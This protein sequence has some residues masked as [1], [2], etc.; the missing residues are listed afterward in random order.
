MDLEAALQDHTI[1]VNVIATI[2]LFLAVFGLRAAGIGFI[3]SQEFAS[4]EDRVRWHVRLRNL[5]LM[6]IIVFLIVIWAEELRTLALSAIAIA[7][8][9]VIAT[10]EMIL[11]ISGGIFR[12]ST[13]TY[14]VGD[15]IEVKGM[16]GDVQSYGL[17]ATKLLEIGPNSQKTGRAV[18]VPHSILLSEPVLNETI[19]ES[20]VLHTIRIPLTS[21]ENWKKAEEDLLA[22]AQEVTTPFIADARKRMAEASEKYGLMRWYPEPKTTLR[23]PE[24]GKIDVIVRLPTPINEKGITEQ[25]VIRRYL[26]KQAG[27]SADSKV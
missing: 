19:M 6:A 13:D 27:R 9:I 26:E 10:K 1:V 23:I 20:Y 21:D 22:A 5:A 12:A 15:R 11:C 16:R 14:R 18:A 7:A 4:D 8:A 24:A 3:R 17:M 25:A 2:V